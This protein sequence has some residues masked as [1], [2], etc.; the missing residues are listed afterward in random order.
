MGGFRGQTHKITM[1]YWS[2][3]KNNEKSSFSYFH[4]E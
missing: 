3:L 1:V 2:N 4:C